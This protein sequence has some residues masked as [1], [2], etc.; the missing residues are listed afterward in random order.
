MRIRINK[1]ILMILWD[2]IEYYT[3]HTKGT[4]HVCRIRDV[5]NDANQMKELVLNPVS[6]NC[7]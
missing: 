2:A 7:I 1:I 4:E 5:S 3:Q 6:L